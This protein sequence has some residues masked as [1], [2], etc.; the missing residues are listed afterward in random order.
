[1]SQLKTFSWTNPATAVARNLDCGFT[2]AEITTVDVTNGGS[3]Y[4]NSAMP[5]GYYLD[6][7]A[8]TITTS[9]GFTPL[10]QSAIFGAS[11]SNFTT[12]NPGVITAANIAQVGIVA[13]DTIEVSAVA[14]SGAGTSKNAQFTVDSVT[15]TAITLNEST[16]GYK[17]YVSGGFVSRISDVNDVPVA[18]DNFAIRGVT[19]GTGVV[20]AN[21]AVMVAVAK[22]SENVT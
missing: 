20:G 2:V 9:N 7:D 11:V 21:N 22:S 16:V 1:M 5:S 17:T 14:E 18:T 3:F 4:W 12:A 13:G 19:A 8:G 15:A 10:A 6:V